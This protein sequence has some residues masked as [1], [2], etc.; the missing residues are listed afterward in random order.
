MALLISFRDHRHY[1]QKVHRHGPPSEGAWGENLI[2]DGLTERNAWIGD[3]F[4]T[5]SSII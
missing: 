4:S 1:W 5:G 2:V 3:M